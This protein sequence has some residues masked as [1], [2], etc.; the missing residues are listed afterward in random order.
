[1]S[2]KSAF[3]SMLQFHY[4]HFL[5]CSLK[6]NRMPNKPSNQLT[7]L[8]SVV[9]LGVAALL[10]TTTD[11]PGPMTTAVGCVGT[12]L[13][14]VTM[15]IPNQSKHCAP[16]KTIFDKKNNRRNGT[17]DDLGA[18][19]PITS[20]IGARLT[21]GIRKDRKGSGAASEEGDAA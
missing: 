17:I 2:L 1:M 3:L 7:R 10:S 19:V 15:L 9:L 11:V 14:P 21:E 20:A 18:S 8:L 12:L 5:V 16:H 6:K 13:V 4:V